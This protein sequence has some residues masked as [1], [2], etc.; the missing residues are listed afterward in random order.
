VLR[1]RLGIAVE[2]GVPDVGL[3]RLDLGYDRLAH[4]HLR[5]HLRLGQVISLPLGDEGRDE[6][7]AANLASH[8]S[9][10]LGFL[11]VR[12]AIER[13]RSVKWSVRSCALSTMEAGLDWRVPLLTISI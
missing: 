10:Y 9:G 5:G 11:A 4:V 8:I 2:R 1:N 3:G 6:T 12:R 13:S 7:L